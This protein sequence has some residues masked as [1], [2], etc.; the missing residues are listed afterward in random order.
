MPATTGVSRTGNAYT[1]GLLGDTKWATTSLTFSFPT[2]GGLYGSGYGQGEN[3][4]NFG[5]L[6]GAQQTAARLS[7]R[8]YSDVAN[9]AF[10][11][12]TGTSAR[13]GDLRFGLSDKPSTAW[14]YMP[15]AADAGGDVWFNKSNG[16]YNSQLKGNYA[17]ATFLH[18][19]GHALGLE[20]PHE[21]GMPLDRDSVEYSVMSYRSYVGASA[22]GGYVNET[23]GYAQSLMMYDIAAIQH[24]YGANFATNGGDT[25]YRWSPSTGEFFVNGVGQGAPAANRILQTVWDG[26]GVDTYDF[27]NHGGALKVDLRPGEWTTT[28]FA[29]LAQLHY[30]GSKPAIGNI[31][32]ALQYNG[33]PRSLIENAKGGSGND[34]I[35]G[36]QAA[37]TLWGNGGADQLF[38]LVGDDRLWGGTGNDWL[39]GGDG[40]DAALFSGASSAARYVSLGGNT[41]LASAEGVDQLWAVERLDFTDRVATLRDNALDYIASHGDLR[42][43]FGADAAAG[44]D[45]FKTSGVFE[46][47]AV[48]FNGLEYLASYADLRAAF[49]IGAGA[50]AAQHFILNGVR[51]GR[52]VLFEGLEY[53]ASYADLRIG[54][55]LNED[56]GTLHFLERALMEGRTVTFD[57]LEYIA[58]HS[59]L[60]QIFRTDR[61]AGAEHFIAYGA[62]EGRHDTFDPA[63]YLAKYGDL[64]T[65]F[66]GD[67]DAATR[68]FIETGFFEG[69]TDDPLMA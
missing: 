37:N 22:T 24:L 44:F 39:D 59:D 47:R 33:D 46:G 15:S 23:G 3:N 43:V 2:S 4:T 60:I 52:A 58:S 57:A 29:Q 16:Y 51:E 35:T 56:G 28:S 54:F 6:N 12:A 8:Q 45:H 34:V 63:G 62:A 31:A 38:G 48:T 17:F 14:A 9:L 26:G 30:N 7:L 50:A 13:Y 42:A 65:A 10:T 64:R 5:V 41:V 49:G 27:S 21:N 19:V 55:G 61:A 69:R 1:D 53:I 68:H 66:G 40:F 36:N 25:T 67:L 18:E 32:N 20:H 11:E